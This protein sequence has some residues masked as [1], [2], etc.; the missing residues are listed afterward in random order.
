M[1]KIVH[2]SSVHPTFENR[3]FH[4]Q[5]AGL[6]RHGHEVILLSPHETAEVVDGVSIVPVFRPAS[7]LAR[8]TLT[9]CDIVRRALAA[10]ADLYHFHDP[11]LIP[12]GLF[13]RLCGRRVIYDVHEDLPRQIMHKEWIPGVLKPAVAAVVGL[14]ESVA[15]RMMSALV[16][17]EPVTARRFRG[18][19]RIAMIQN[20][21]R[22]EEF[23]LVD[24]FVPLNERPADVVYIGAITRARGA[25]EMVQAIA[26]VP[27][28]L[29]ARLLLGGSIDDELLQELQRLDGWKSTDYLGVLSRSQ[30]L[31]VLNRS[32]IGLVVLHP[33]PKYLEAWPTK[34]FEYMMMKM[35]VIASNFPLWQEI[36]ENAEC[37]FTVDPTDPAAIAELITRLLS[38][39]QAAAALGEHG[40]NCVVEKYNWSVE[41]QKLLELYRA[42]LAP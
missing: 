5:C 28:I 20:F 37:G 27:P 7:R 15:C 8:F 34:L 38:D 17:A 16:V 10:K 13:L 33:T 6:A 19:R 39:A 29:R 14:C 25:R 26:R 12:A 42:V 21:P 41:E 23:G 24:Q 32:R 1:A 31:S 40:A 30:V 9:A 11:E 35:P 2:F 18:A 22:L 3:I 4:K 36:V